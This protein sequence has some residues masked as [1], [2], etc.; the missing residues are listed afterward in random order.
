MIKIEKE[1][2][3]YTVEE[4]FHEYCSLYFDDHNIVNLTEKLYD[5]DLSNSVLE[6]HLELCLSNSFRLDPSFFVLGSFRD[7]EET[8]SLDEKSFDHVF[9]ESPFYKQPISYFIGS[10]AYENHLFKNNLKDNKLLNIAEKMIFNPAVEKG[11]SIE[12]DVL[13]IKGI[14]SYPNVVLAKERFIT[15][16]EYIRELSIY[17]TMFS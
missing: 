8:S 16:R 12:D 4:G 15:F 7:L 3:I 13:D 10:M 11:H 14:H 5:D 6:E 17:K 9:K 2:F 1:D